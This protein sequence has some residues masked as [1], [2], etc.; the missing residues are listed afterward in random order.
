LQ[1]AVNGHFGESNKECVAD[2][3]S[4]K[5]QSAL[6]QPATCSLPSSSAS[7]KKRKCEPQETAVPTL[8]KYLPD[9]NKTCNPSAG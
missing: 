1:K 3:E 7:T 6:Q 4:S 9:Q 2:N 5:G 8:M